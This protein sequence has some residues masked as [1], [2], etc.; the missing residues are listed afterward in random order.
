MFITYKTNSI[1]KKSKNK[2]SPICRIGQTIQT[3]QQPVKNSSEVNNQEY[4]T[5]NPPQQ[6]GMAT[7]GITRRETRQVNNLGFVGN[8]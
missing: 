4:K 2:C 6:Q 5:M 3:R 1:N 7:L 8:S